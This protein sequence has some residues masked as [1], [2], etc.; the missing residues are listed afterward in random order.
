MAN[1]LVIINVCVFGKTG[2]A[3][4]V[5]DG[6]ISTNNETRFILILETLISFNLQIDSL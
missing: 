6:L 3:H 1:L 5:H 4:G 2:G